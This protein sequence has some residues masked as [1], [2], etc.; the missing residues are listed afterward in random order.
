MTRKPLAVAW[1]RKRAS[2]P[3][4]C[5]AQLR[6]QDSATGLACHTMR[7]AEL[8]RTSRALAL[9]PSSPGLSTAQAFAREA[10]AQ[11]P[12]WRLS[13]VTDEERLRFAAAIA[14]PSLGGST[15]K[16]MRPGSRRCGWSP[17]PARRRDGKGQLK[18]RTRPWLVRV[19]V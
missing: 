1:T 15:F 3:S 2:V 16:E 6:V 14:A 8:S 11:P 7:H 10:P 4:E 13:V 9:F 18:P 5:R 17:K 19:M 12:L